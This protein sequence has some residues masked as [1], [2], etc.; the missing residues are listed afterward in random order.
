MRTPKRVLL[1]LILTLGLIGSQTWAPAVKAQGNFSA[2]IQLALRNLLAGNQTIT[3]NWTCSGTCS[4]FGGGGGGTVT[5]T[6]SANQVA[7]WSG[8]SA[9]GGSA[10]FTAVAGNVT[11]TSFTGSLAGSTGLPIS[12]GVSGLGTG[13]ATWLATPSSANLASALT[14]ETGTNLAVFDTAPTLR[15]TVT[16]GTAGGTTGAAL[17]KG[18]TSGIVTLST[19]AAAGT[20]TMK[21]PTT[22]GTVN[23]FLQTD[24]SGNTTWAAGGGG[25]TIGTTAITSGTTTRI[26]YDN[27]GVVGEYTLTGTGTVVVMATAPTITGP[28]TIS[29]AVGSSGLTITGA[30]QTS[31]FPALNV[32]QI[33]NNGATTFKGALIN[34]TNTGSAAASALLDAQVSGS[35]RFSVTPTTINWSD[36]AQTASFATS[37]S[38]FT[39]T[40]S[41]NY[42]A[43]SAGFGLWITPNGA[44]LAFGLSGDIILN[45]VAAADLQFGLDVNGAGVSQ[46]IRAANGITGTD[47]TGGNFTL[48]SGKGTGAGAV[49]SLIFQTPTV[50]GSGTTAQ[51]LATRLTIVETLSTFTNTVKAA[52]Y[53]SSDGTAGAT[54]TSC[55]GFK[56]GLC[57]SG[58]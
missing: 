8:A 52:G 6:G 45:R 12:S 32:T 53:Q 29:E 20:W 9:I 34:I 43:V 57:I 4:G 18:T 19:A 38:G 48:A 36:G 55:T 49:S 41:A 50:L 40:T 14:D 16:I 21:L 7:V 31:S 10:G 22:A 44:R 24:G 15:S 13:I 11:A 25:I 27:A 39:L 35:T 37:S 28:A 47:K 2:Q 26:L 51:S 17:F 23:Y 33:W 56:N 5:G 54:V 1:A 58:T 42:F 30:T 3:G 46:T